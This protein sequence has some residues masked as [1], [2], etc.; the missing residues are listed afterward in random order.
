MKFDKAKFK[1]LHL[2]WGNPQYLYRVGD[3]WIESS[4]EEKNLGIP[5]I[6][7]FSG[8]VSVNLAEGYTT[9]RV[10]LFISD[11]DKGMECTLSK[12]A[13]DTKLSGAADTPE[14]WD[15]IQRGLD[16][17]KEWACGISLGLTRLSFRC[18]TWVE[19]TS[20]ISPG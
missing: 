8:E 2:G 4:P 5:A 14:G 16:K 12:F 20:G 9:P 18:C 11:V 6:F 15:A 7:H 10:Q 1:F 17:L 3:E 19:A 13:D